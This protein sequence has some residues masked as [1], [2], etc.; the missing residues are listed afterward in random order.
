MV[1][2]PFG[3][4][5]RSKSRSPTACEVGPVKKKPAPDRTREVEA[6]LVNDPRGGLH[7]ERFARVRDGAFAGVSRFKRG[8][9]A[10]A[11]IAQRRFVEFRRPLA[12]RVA[13]PWRLGLELR[14]AELLPNHLGAL[15]IFALGQR[16][17]REVLF[18]SGVDQH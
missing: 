5:S 8:D 1:G 14:Q 7:K 10:T 13:E 17:R 15:H 9:I 4:R 6:F 3:P 2:S 11:V 12:E 16:D 18:Q